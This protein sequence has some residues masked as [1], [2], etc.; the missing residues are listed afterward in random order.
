MVKTPYN[1]P[2]NLKNWEVE[3]ASDFNGAEKVYISN[4][5]G[6]SNHIIVNNENGNFLGLLKDKSELTSGITYFTRVRQ[7]STN[8]Q[9]SAWS[10]WHQGFKVE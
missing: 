8:G 10:G 2:G 9:W 4:S 7:Q 1:G 6:E 3:L 5:S